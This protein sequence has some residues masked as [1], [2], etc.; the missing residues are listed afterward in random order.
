M[1]KNNPI[2]HTKENAIPAAKE[3]KLNVVVLNGRIIKENN[4]VVLP[5]I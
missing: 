5:V 3:M 4:S 2:V 1:D